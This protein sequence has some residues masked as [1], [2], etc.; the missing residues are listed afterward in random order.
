MHGTQ[1]CLGNAH[2]LC[3]HEHLSLPDFY[4][5]LSCMNYQTPFPSDIGK[6]SLARRCAQ[7]VG[8]NWEDSGV[9]K[10]IEGKEG[11]RE[12]LA[13]EGYELLMDNVEQTLEANVSR[14]CTIRIDSTIAKGGVRNCQVDGGVWTGCDV[15]SSLTDAG[16]S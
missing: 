5:V 3:L 11:K 4:A 14:S 8:V 10:C 13:K 16:K 15:S 9:A 12:G 7:T 6:V 2:Q 1:E